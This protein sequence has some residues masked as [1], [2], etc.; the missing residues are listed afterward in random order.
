M[1]HYFYIAWV[2]STKKNIILKISNEGILF[3]LSQGLD[4]TKTN[5]PSRKFFRFNMR[6]EIYWEVEMLSFDKSNYSLQVR[7]L[8]Y[9]MKYEEE[10][11]ITQK[12]KY[13]I[14]R[15]MFHD[16]I[17]THL[18]K[19]LSKYK[20]SAF[21]E[22]VTFT[23]EKEIVTHESQAT[24]P[25]NEPYELLK[26]DMKYPLMK[27]TFKMGYVELEKKIRALDQT[28]KIQ[29]YNDHIIPEFDYVK[30]FFKKVLGKKTIDVK[31]SIL[32]KI[33]GEPVVKCHSNAIASINESFISSVKRLKLRNAIFDPK[34]VPVDKSLFTPEEYFEETSENLGNALNRNDKDIFDELMELDDIRNKRELMYL[35][36]KLQSAQSRLKFTLSPTFGF[37]FHI[38]GEEMDHFVWELLDSHATYI[39]SIEKYELNLEVKYKLLEREINFI[40]DNGR[41][42]YLQH[43][44][45]SE[46]VFNKIKHSGSGFVDGFVKWKSQLNEMM[47]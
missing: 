24:K 4:W 22:I 18:E 33:N 28:V 42:L 39:W 32:L 17:W 45:E 26:I 1:S 7:I 41:R 15:L 12:P 10:Q 13:Q 5:F 43:T 23:F 46:F 21:N 30:P 16:L 8:D 31:G 11:F 3:N 20:K 25:N 44:H 6:K 47:I 34:V 9:D 40:R 38:P 36:G 14:R 37:L 2:A 35:S 27:T 19:H 29:L